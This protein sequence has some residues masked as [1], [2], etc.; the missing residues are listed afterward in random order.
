M[1]RFAFETLHTRLPVK[2]SGRSCYLLW[3]IPTVVRFELRVS[4][5]RSTKG[6]PTLQEHLLAIVNDTLKGGGHAYLRRILYPLLFL[7]V[8]RSAASSLSGS[9]T[10]CLAVDGHTRPR[11]R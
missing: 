2:H 1:S 5:L 7:T 4:L 11:L 6:A 8:A 10:P 3:M 9:R